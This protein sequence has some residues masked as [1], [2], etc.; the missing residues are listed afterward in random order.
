MLTLCKT[1]SAHARKDPG[2]GAA[3]VDDAGPGGT[4]EENVRSCLDRCIALS[5]GACHGVTLKFKLTRSGGLSCWLRAHFKMHACIRVPGR[6]GT[7]DYF[8]Y[9]R[10]AAAPLLREPLLSA[11]KLRDVS[12]HPSCALEY[13]EPPHGCS[14]NVIPADDVFGLALTRPY[15]AGSYARDL[16]NMTSRTCC[17]VAPTGMNLQPSRDWRTLE[18]ADVGV[19]MNLAAASVADPALDGSAQLD[20]MAACASGHSLACARL[21]WMAAAGPSLQVLGLVDCMHFCGERSKYLLEDAMPF[22]SDLKHTKRTHGPFDNVI[23]RSALLRPQPHLADLMLHCY[24][25]K[26]SG[27]GRSYLKTAVLIETLLARMPSKRFYMK[28]DADAMLRPDNLLE[29]LRRVSHLDERQPLYFG[30]A[31]GMPNCLHLRMHEKGWIIPPK[32]RFRGRALTNTDCGHASDFREG[33][34]PRARRYDAGGGPANHT[35]LKAKLKQR[36]RDSSTWQALVGSIG[37]SSITGHGAN[38]TRLQRLT[39]AY[40][41]AY[42]FSQRAAEILV[43]TKCIQRLGHMECDAGRPCERQ[44]GSHGITTHEDV[45]VG[46]CMSLIGAPLLQCDCFHNKGPGYW[47]KYVSRG[48]VLSGILPTALRNLSTMRAMPDERVRLVTNAL[49]TTSPF[50]VRFFL[51]RGTSWLCRH[52]IIVHPVTQPNEWLDLWHALNAWDSRVAH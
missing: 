12:L 2:K 31:L 8:T 13:N 7:R 14:S 45:N 1:C 43:R 15:T 33:G 18:W 38:V 5:S 34:F 19:G 20:E 37:Q 11:V 3:D 49:A 23:K 25:V 40:G 47:M 22:C 4:N 52:P 41:G 50:F 42:G 39:Y 44:A 6:G 36:V 26:Y 46:L 30:S 29:F 16:S 17:A 9:T 32:W 10:S 28:L 21:T 51:P 48:K 24:W 35:G 27:L